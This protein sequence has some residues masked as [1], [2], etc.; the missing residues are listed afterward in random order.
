MMRVLKKKTGILPA[1]RFLLIFNPIGIRQQAPF[2]RIL[3]LAAID[4]HKI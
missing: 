2:R 4:V 1:E 3:W